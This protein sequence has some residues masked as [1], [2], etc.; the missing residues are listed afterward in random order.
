M[1]LNSKLAAGT[2]IVGVVMMSMSVGFGHWGLNHTTWNTCSAEAC[3]R[4]CNVCCAFFFGGIGN[5]NGAGCYTGCTTLPL[6]PP[7]GGAC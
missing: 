4:R 2:A 3:Q 5:P 6:N 7:G 1:N